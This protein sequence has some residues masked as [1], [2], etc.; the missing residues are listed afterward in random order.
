MKSKA[1]LSVA[2]LLGISPLAFAQKQAPPAE[3][4]PADAPH[5]MQSNQDP[6]E[7]AIWKTC[8]N[9]P[10]SPLRA[11]GPPPSGPVEGVRDAK[12]TAIPGVIAADAQWN[13]VW[14]Q[15]GNNGDGII[16]T[17]DG[18]LLLAQNDSS[19]VV[20]L[21]KEG[22]ASVIYKDTNTGGALSISTKGAIFIVERGVN[23]TVTELA[24]ERKTFADKFDGEPLDCLNVVIN[25]LAADSKG[26][27]YFT[28]GALY[29]AN[30]K[31]EISKYGADLHTNGIVLSHDEKTIYV[32]DNKR[33]VAFEIQPDGSLTNEHEF[34]KLEG[35]GYGD[36]TTIDSEGRL[37]VTTGPGVQVLGPD[38]KYLGLIPTPR[39]VISAAFSGKDKKTLYI[40]ARGAKDQAGN[41]V[42]NAAQVYTIQMIAQGFKKRAK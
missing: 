30:P 4:L 8:K 37:Y 23:P 25:D 14:Q 15:L 2:L 20:K 26:G 32:T 27:V 34:G 6:K 12:I 3:P 17:S 33:V 39:G 5:A 9:P 10:T 11:P 28:M 22:H 19:A 36:G 40:L 31:G 29:Y 1:F 21:D 7:A 16:G 13:F 42:G 38:G 24:P 35:G 18:G 41:E